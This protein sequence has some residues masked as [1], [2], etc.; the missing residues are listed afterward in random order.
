MT[1]AFSSSS[2][3][4]FSSMTHGVA[5]SSAGGTLRVAARASPFTPTIRLLR[6]D[7]S[8]APMFWCTSP[9]YPLRPSTTSIWS[10]RSRIVGQR[11]LMSLRVGRSPS[12]AF[13]PVRR[14]QPRSR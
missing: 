7:R 12:A 9:A 11:A 1:N 6:R 5:N 8:A 2:A 10:C 14:F 3:R 13:R 4:S